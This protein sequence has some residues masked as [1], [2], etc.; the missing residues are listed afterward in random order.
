MSSKELGALIL[1]VIMS[2]QV[3][4]VTVVLVF[5][6]SLVFSVSRLSRKRRVKKAAARSRPKKLRGPAPMP[7]RDEA[8]REGEDELGLEEESSG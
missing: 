5:Y 3:I 7:S 2:W 1:G 4:A 8:T 6:L